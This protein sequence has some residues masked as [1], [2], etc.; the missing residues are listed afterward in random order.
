M[1]VLGKKGLLGDVRNAFLHH[2]NSVVQ[3]Q[4]VDAPHVLDGFLNHTLASLSTPQ[5]G[6]DQMHLSPF[7]PN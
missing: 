2:L 6:L 5:I 1:S 3:N 7:F 4:D